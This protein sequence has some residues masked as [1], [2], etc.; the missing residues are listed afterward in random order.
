MRN[1]AGAPHAQ[2]VLWRDWLLIPIALMV[3]GADQLAKLSVQHWMEVGQSI[4]NTGLFRFTYITNTGASFSLFP[5][6]SLALVVAS[7]FAIAVLLLFYGGYARH[8]PLV[9]L[10]LGLQLGG[11]VGNLTDRLWH[12]YVVDFVDAGRWP[13]FN[14]AD[15]AIVAGLVVLLFVV[16]GEGA[17]RPRAVQ[18]PGPPPEYRPGAA[19][20]PGC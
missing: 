8:N 10:S 4:P 2:A 3:A 7:F 1:V 18:W 9:R 20:D 12:G 14:L 16:T 19:P 6:Q 15:S 17:R 11:A 5:N 13:V